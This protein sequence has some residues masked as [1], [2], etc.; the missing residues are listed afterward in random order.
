MIWILM[1]MLILVSVSVTS[2][3]ITP[4]GNGKITSKGLANVDTTARWNVDYST[5][6]GYKVLIE[7]DTKLNTKICLYSESAKSINEI[8]ISKELYNEKNQLI[9]TLSRTATSLSADS[10]YGYCFTPTTQTYL[11]FGLHSTVIEYQN[12]SKILYNYDWGSTSIQLL[13][14]DV[15]ENNIYVYANENKGYKFGAIDNSMNETELHNFTYIIDTTS[16]FNALKKDVY[17]NWVE[18]KKEYGLR[19]VLKEVNDTWVGVNEDGYTGEIIQFPY[20]IT[21]QENYTVNEW[22]VTHRDLD[23]SYLDI[24]NYYPNG[25]KELRH[26]YSF[27][28]VCKKEYADCNWIVNENQIII[29]F[30]SD[31]F[32]DPTI[33]N[34]SACAT[35]N[36]YNTTY[37]LNESI[38]GIVGDCFIINNDSIT[39]DLNS[40][41]IYGSNDDTSGVLNYG[42]DN[43]TVINGAIYNFSYGVAMQNALYGNATFLDII[44]EHSPHEVIGVEYYNMSYSTAQYNFITSKTDGIWF[45]AVGLASYEGSYNLFVGNTFWDIYTDASSAWGYHADGELNSI[46]KDGYSGLITGSFSSDHMFESSEGLVIDHLNS[47]TDEF[48]ETFYVSWSNNITFKNNI[49]VGPDVFIS[50]YY[51][52]NVTANNNT[53]YADVWGVGN[54]LE[55]IEYAPP[56]DDDVYYDHNITLNNTIDGG[57][58][59]Y[60][61]RNDN[62]A[63]KNKQVGMLYCYGSSNHSYTNLTDAPSLQTVQCDNMNIDGYYARGGAY[64]YIQYS[65]N[66]TTNNLQ[67]PYVSSTFGIRFEYGNNLHLSN[68][69]ANGP[70]NYILYYTTMTNSQATNIYLNS[71]YSSASLGYIQNGYNLSFYNV[72]TRGGYNGFTISSTDR[73][74]MNGFDLAPLDYSSHYIYLTSV[75][76]S[77][78]E[79]GVLRN[80]VQRGIYYYTNYIN[81]KMR[82]ILFKDII[83]IN[84]STDEEVYPYSLYSEMRNITFLNVT[85]I[86][87]RVAQVSYTLGYNS[88]DRY[89]YYTPLNIT[90]VYGNPIYN[91]TI[92]ISGADTLCFQDEATSDNCGATAGGYSTP[93][94]WFYAT[95]EKPQGALNTSLW[96]VDHANKGTYTINL[97]IECWNYNS[98]HIKM[99][100]YSNVNGNP[101]DSYWQCQRNG[102]AWQTIGQTANE[103]GWDGYLA[104]GQ[105]KLYDERVY[106][107]DS[108]SSGGVPYSGQYGRWVYPK[109][110]NGGGDRAATLQEEGMLWKFANTITIQTDADGLVKEQSLIGDWYL[111]NNLFNFSNYTISV[112]K[113]GYYPNGTDIQLNGNL[114][115]HLNLLAEE[116][117]APTFDNLINLFLNQNDSLSYDLNATDLYG[118][119]KFWFNSS[120]FFGING[121]DGWITNTS[122]TDY[123]GYK[124]FN[125]SVND[126]HGNTNSSIMYVKVVKLPS[127]NKK[128]Q[129]FM[130][131]TGDVNGWI[132]N[133]GTFYMR[134]LIIKNEYT[135]PTA[136][137]DCKKGQITYDSNYMY[138]CV[139]DDTWKRAGF[140]TW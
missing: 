131:S 97:S 101:Y 22:N 1:A 135:P 51:S 91:A 120:L 85:G 28:D 108:G 87:Y 104:Y 75:E 53:V 72:T 133:A 106:V 48:D 77:T 83:I 98:T 59:I 124:W 119:D 20:N 62:V 134:D 25:F 107:A 105:A 31:K 60:N 74:Y 138:I 80:E 136:S 5:D 45:N 123:Y 88:E 27:Q 52:T 90:D 3:E 67:F 34:V 128:L 57:I 61:F 81:N 4:V 127:P 122:D 2:K 14:D 12:E 6:T 32:I 129:S 64:L 68:L 47:N 21:I 63:V 58:T 93:A 114:N 89:S 46:F 116:F 109:P 132:D 37:I 38:H 17:Y 15:V 130:N 55:I 95:Y 23:Y 36:D 112:T 111:G 40:K 79:K 26:W 69:Y 70:S 140:G 65:D 99:R 49:A 82:D 39:V 115:I 102:G 96:V 50:L 139:W 33:E 121:A 86:R 10:K 42:F 66:V 110:S 29:N 56:P 117:D 13:K 76:N 11:K 30:V 9:T 43:C 137:T 35:L 92:V 100:G 8:P 94:Y 24:Y 73:V 78:F 118:I 126:T 41:I 113:S 16:K 44:S 19:D 7:D 84:E 71:T 125:V 54:F 18:V 103:G